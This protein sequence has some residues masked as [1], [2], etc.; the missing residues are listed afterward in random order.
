MPFW[1]Q[2]LTLL[3]LHCVAS[4]GV[5]EVASA[6]W[7]PV[8]SKVPGPLQTLSKQGGEGNAQGCFPSPG[9]TERAL[10]S[11]LLIRAP[12]WARVSSDP[13]QPLLPFVTELSRTKP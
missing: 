13:Q 10:L 1:V 8:P 12:L 2:I 5:T 3:L 11:L 4:G 7:K 6:S 9:P